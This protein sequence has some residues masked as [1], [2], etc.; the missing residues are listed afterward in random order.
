M[1]DKSIGEVIGRGIREGK[2]LDIR[3]NN[4]QGKPS[5]FWMCVFDV[6]SEGALFGKIFNLTKDEPIKEGKIFMS[7][8]QN[9]EILVFSQYDVPK[10]LIDKLDNDD[11]LK[12]FNFNRYND[13]LLNYYLECYKANQDPFLHKEHLIP[14]LDLEVISKHN[15]YQLSRE[16]MKGFMKEI[17]QERYDKYMHY[18]LALSEFSIDMH[19]KGKFIVAYRKLRFDPVEERLY[20]SDRTSFNPSFYIKSIKHS[21]SNYLDISPADFESDYE[22]NKQE[23]IEKFRTNF[24]SV[25]MLNT[26]PEIVVLGYKQS[27]INQVYDEINFDIAN[28]KLEVPIKAFFEKSSILDRQNRTEPNIVLYDEQ[29][30][31][32]QLRTI[33]GALKYP[34]TYVQGPPGTGKTQTILNI[35]INC[36]TSNR[37][38]LIAS[39]NNTPIDGIKDKLVLGQYKSKDIL[40]PLLRLGNDEKIKSAITQIR[41]LYEFETNDVPKETLLLKIKESSKEKN[42][43]LNERIKQ[44]EDRMH[45]EQ[46]LGFI[47]SLIE[48]NNNS[49]LEQERQATEKKLNDIPKLEPKDV[50]KLFEVVKGNDRLLQF[51]YYESLKYVKRLKTKAYS[52]LIDILYLEEEAD[53]LKAFKKWLAIDENLDKLTK[54][55]PVILSTNLSCVKLG[56]SFK[57]DL[58]ALDE[59]G[60]CDIATSLIPISKCKNMVLI[61][62]TNQLKPIV[63]FEE[64]TNKQLMHQFDIPKVYDYFNNSILSTYKAIDH[65]SNNILLSYHYR[66]GEKIINYS[67]QRFYE[68][69]LNLTAIK[70]PGELIVLGVNNRNHKNKNSNLE[71]AVEIVRYIK[72]NKLTDAFI[73]TPFR[74]QEEVLNHYLKEAKVLNEID[75][76]VSCGTIH[77][78]QGQENRNIIISTSIS[79]KTTDKT[80]D[81]IKN[82]SQLINVGVT[83]A[84]ERL[85]FV[86]DSKAIDR[87]SRKDDDLYA[88]YDYISKNGNTQVAQST[89]NKFTIGY[90]N[91]SVFEDEFYKT[92]SHYCT[93]KGG[94]FKRNVKVI[95]V[96]PEDRNNPL[97][98]RKEFD[99]VLYTGPKL[100]VVFE[101]HG[102]EHSTNKKRQASD[103]RKRDFLKSKGV[104]FIEIPNYY[105]KHYE[106]IGELIN[107]IRGETFQMG[108]F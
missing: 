101:V 82:N 69:K 107:K 49:L 64:A 68:N 83:R 47:N 29:V 55:F 46:V 108:L 11:S 22:Q 63:V 43:L 12:K 13:N 18:E 56:R 3:Y 60:Q 89:S 38:L 31:I 27:N 84:K 80:Y 78:V 71:E 33:Y 93:V 66:C 42:K 21:L 105:V 37:T 76:T 10:Q 57:F 98:N 81:W 51:F 99:G 62:D 28:N 34:I 45:H 25:E 7:G 75:E 67:N 85:V 103:Q 14:G 19:S 102:F 77:K 96:F 26:K 61:G 91:D 48:T 6:T 41:K 72:E 59:A 100:E 2:Y 16:Q 73:L 90:S 4:L 30:N 86:V 39:N 40:F 20:I 36:L 94:R 70:K 5:R 92:M 1:I 44:Y 24:R 52:H 9:A 54:V 53:Q 97:I 15:P 23:T 8:I 88:L 106:I 87:L 58:L 95:E 50:F 74:H 104:K 65:I 35:V 79:E 17:Y 32:D